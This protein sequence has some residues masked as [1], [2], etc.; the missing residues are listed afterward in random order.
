MSTITNITFE[1]WESKFLP[2]V[3]HISPEASFADEEGRGIM[4]ETYGLEH[5]YVQNHINENK[6]WTWVDGDDGSY[7]IN[8]YHLFNRI[9]YFVTEVPYN[10]D[11]V[12]EVLV[13]T[14][15]KEE[16]Q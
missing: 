14:Y 10:A 11:S 4:F 12:Y 1:D 13:D 16:Q 3:N 6:V 9:G 7:V 8:G 2:V 15:N 5:M